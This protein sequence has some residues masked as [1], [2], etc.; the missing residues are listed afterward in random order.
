MNDSI[1]MKPTIDMM[2][3]GA[4]FE[5]IIMVAAKIAAKVVKWFTFGEYTI[6]VDGDIL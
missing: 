6:N 1:N 5:A 4:M 3:Q 2:D